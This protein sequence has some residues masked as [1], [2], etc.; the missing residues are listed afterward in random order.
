MIGIQ[1]LIEVKKDFIPELIEVYVGDDSDQHFAKEWHKYRE[2]IEYP[3]IVIEDKDNLHNVDWRFAFK[4]TV[5]IR[6]NDTD[7]MI[8][9]Y[10]LINKCMP[11]R[12]FIF[13]NEKDYTEIIDSKGLL[14]G[15][16]E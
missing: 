3:S 13:H 8:K 12:I 9:V 2:T 15:I 4:S 10:E 7:R 14:S 5:F 16:I 11:E 1:E 6:G